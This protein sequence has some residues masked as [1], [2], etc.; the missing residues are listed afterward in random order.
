MQIVHVSYISIKKKLQEES[1]V[2]SFL[3]SI[4]LLNFN[5]DLS[6]NM[7]SVLE[8]GVIIAYP[9]MRGSKI[10]FFHFMLRII[11]KEL[12]ISTRNG[13]M[14]DAEREG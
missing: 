8:R 2:F 14:L 10:L 4:S 13:Q 11:N 7:V 12:L 1:M 3:N 5:L 6:P 9:H